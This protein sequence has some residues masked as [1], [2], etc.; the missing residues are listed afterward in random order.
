MKEITQYREKFD[1]Y[2]LKE[3]RKFNL[4]PSQQFQSF[5]INTSNGTLNLETALRLE[6]INS[7]ERFTSRTKGHLARWTSACQKIFNI[8]KLN[9]KNIYYTAGN[10]YFYIYNSKAIYIA[11]IITVF[12]KYGTSY[13]QAEYLDGL[14]ANRIHAILYKQDLLNLYE[15]NHILDSLK[16]QFA[17]E[18]YSFRFFSFLGKVEVK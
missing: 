15:F 16:I 1:E 2:T 5:V 6:Q 7:A 14:N 4:T 9:P 13:R 3:M 17:V 12:K 11:E 18:E 8:T 10:F